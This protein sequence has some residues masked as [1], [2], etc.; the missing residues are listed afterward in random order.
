[1]GAP[2][3]AWAAVIP[4][5]LLSDGGA[6]MSPGRRIR[7]GRAAP[8]SL[9]PPLLAHDSPENLLGRAEA[10]R[11]PACPRA[12]RDTEH[13]TVYNAGVWK[14]RAQPLPCT[15]D[16]CIELR[17]LTVSVRIAI[18]AAARRRTKA[19][20]WAPRGRNAGPRSPAHRASRRARP[21]RRRQRKPRV[22]A[23]QT[24]ARRRWRRLAPARGL[25]GE[26]HGGAIRGRITPITPASPRYP[27]QRPAPGLQS[28]RG[29]ILACL[30]SRRRGCGLLWGSRSRISRNDHG[31]GGAPQRRDACGGDGLGP[32]GVPPCAA[33]ASV[34]KGMD[35]GLT[36]RRLIRIERWQTHTEIAEKSNEGS[37]LNIASSTPNRGS[38]R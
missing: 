11:R 17:V 36:G 13:N 35:S 31:R 33:Q 2:I 16:Q 8:V 1:M 34:V 32:V 12:R 20:P 37:S 22:P 30:R 4:C 19:R 29:V 25:Y 7:D 24:R 26:R 23:R 3:G 21:P 6:E 18:V 5:S 28:G 9:S 27:R 38:R 15:D 10:T 14:R